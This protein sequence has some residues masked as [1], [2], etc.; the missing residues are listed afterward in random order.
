M[1]TGVSQLLGAGSE[2]TVRSLL[3]SRSFVEAATV[4]KQT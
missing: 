4:K 3:Q 2:K 1:E